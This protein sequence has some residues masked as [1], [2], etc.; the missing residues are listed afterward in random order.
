M[1]PT[2]PLPREDVLRLRPVR[3]PAVVWTEKTEDAED[4]GENA[5][6]DA[7]TLELPGRSDR[8][9]IF[10]ER[11][12]G[13]PGK[14]RVG[15]D[16]FGARIWTLCDGAHTVDDLVGVTSSQYK[17]NRRQAEVSVLAFMK[18]LSQRRLIGYVK[19]ERKQSDVNP[20]NRRR[21]RRPRKTGQ[22]R[23]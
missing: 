8:F 17:L 2:P 12:F 15:L 11:F 18:M 6:A 1:K 20:G 7:M 10:L 16:A 21:P 9:G 5:S 3:N 19:D 23:G 13:P 22:R 4:S 14:R